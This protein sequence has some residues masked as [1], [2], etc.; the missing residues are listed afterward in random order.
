M[1]QEI[2]ADETSHSGRPGKHSN[3]GMYSS[4]RRDPI[5]KRPL[6]NLALFFSLLPLFA[7]QAVAQTQPQGQYTPPP[8]SANQPAAPAMPPP[9]TAKQ[10]DQFVA[11]IALYPDPL[12]AQ[13]LTASTFWDQIPE[14]ATWASM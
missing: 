9:H 4:M 5:R 14:A 3:F 11:R 13:I 7:L 10:L 6:R 1:I 8:P 2:L 12:L